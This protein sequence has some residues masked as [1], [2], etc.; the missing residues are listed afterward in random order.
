MPEQNGQHVSEEIHVEREMILPTI[1]QYVT[2]GKHITEMDI[3]L[4]TV[5]IGEGLE[6]TSV[7]FEQH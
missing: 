3:L 2:V 6:N 1:E 7:G 5:M 4:Q